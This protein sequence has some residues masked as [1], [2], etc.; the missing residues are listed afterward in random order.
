MTIRNY[1]LET[2]DCAPPNGWTRGHVTLHL[3]HPDE[4]VAVEAWRRGA[5]AVH[6]TNACGHAV[7]THAS[8][9][10]GI[11]TSRSMEEGALIVERIEPLANWE[12]IDVN[13]KPA[14]RDKVRSVI[15][16]IEQRG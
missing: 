13:E 11:W 5:F 8:T 15:D 16:E 3:V 7:I 10:R 4:R 9:G 14:L 6:P 2:T 12:A 1:Y